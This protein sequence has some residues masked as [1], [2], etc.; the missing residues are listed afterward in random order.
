MNSYPHHNSPAQN[1]AYPSQ[2]TMPPPNFPQYDRSNNTT[3]HW[4]YSNQ[5]VPLPLPPHD[6]TNIAAPSNANADALLAYATYTTPP[7]SLARLA[8]LSMPLCLPQTTSGPTSLFARGYSPALE[9]VGITMEEW[10][11]FVYVPSYCV[12]H[13]SVLV[14]AV[15]LT[16]RLGM[17]LISPWHPAHLYVF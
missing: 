14:A 12:V 9:D 13:I 17:D 4:D 2:T 10:L 1:W 15:E 6:R 7:P 16:I 8:T 11:R 3:Q 5:S